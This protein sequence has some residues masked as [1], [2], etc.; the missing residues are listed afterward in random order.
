MYTL[1]PAEQIAHRV[2]EL[3]AIITDA[4]RGRPVSIGVVA[5]RDVS[6][7]DPSYPE[8]NQVG[9][10]AQVIKMLR[11]PDGNTTVIIQGK[12][13]FQLVEMIQNEPYIRAKIEHP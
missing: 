13:R 4:Y 11:M 5:L 7:E 3:G 9:T 1:L 6:V 8:L 2:T 10:V 12:K